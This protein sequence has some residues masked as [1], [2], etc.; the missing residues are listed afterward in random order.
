MATW[1]DVS[2]AAA[3]LPEL[4]ERT[5][6]GGFEWRVRNKP[7]AWERPLRRGDLE[8][9]GEAAPE[10]PILAVRVPHVGV[11]E[12]LLSENPEVFFTTP[13]FDGYPAILIRLDAIGLPEL[14]EVLTEGWLAQA[15]KWLAAV[16][17][18][19]LDGH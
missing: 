3:A 1:E 14:A 7:V 2:Q 8:A 19:S 11:K 13:H 16:Y 5:D 15:P 12:A 17:L 10:G 9:L 6:R 4:A 18:E